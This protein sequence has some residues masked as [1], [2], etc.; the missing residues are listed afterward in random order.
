ML[1]AIYCD[2]FGIGHSDYINRILL[3]FVSLFDFRIRG[4]HVPT[5]S[6]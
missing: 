6:P 2:Q 5:V 3:L 4:G 1:S